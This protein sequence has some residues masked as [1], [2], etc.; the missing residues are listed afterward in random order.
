MHFL[1]NKFVK[2][3]ILVI[4]LQVLPLIIFGCGG[5]GGGGS[6]GG[7]VLPV[8]PTNTPSFITQ[9]LTPGQP[10]NVNIGDNCILKFSG[11]SVTQQCTI[12]CQLVQSK[13]LPNLPAGLQTL[14][15]IYVIT[16]DKPSAYVANSANLEIT[17]NVSTQNV[18]IYTDYNIPSGTVWTNLNTTINGQKLS[19][20]CPGFSNTGTSYVAVGP[21]NLPTETPSPT[22][23]ALTP[24][25]APGAPTPTPVLGTPTSTPIVGTPTAIPPT[26]TPVTYTVTYNVNGG[27]GGNA[28]VDSNHYVQGSTVT[29]LDFTGK[30]VKPS[31]RWAGWNTQADGLGTDRAVGST[32]TASSNVTLYAKWT[33]TP[34]ALRVTGPAGGLIFYDKGSY[35]GSPAWRYLEAAP[36]DYPENPGFPQHSL[37]PWDDSNPNVNI[38]GGTA[39]GIGTG[40]Q[41]TINIVVSKGSDSYAALVCY[42]LVISGYDDWFLP[43]KDELDKIYKELRLFGVGGFA[44]SYYWSSSAYSLQYAWEQN[45]IN[46][47]QGYTSK[48]SSLSVRAV[49]AF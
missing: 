15:D 40:Q 23:G 24:T 7:G 6:T 14:S 11:N 27:N 26:P 19:T 37:P 18:C 17:I 28:P 21:S 36:S 41:N 43:S 42:E 2:L 12:T 31:Y 22:P 13:A 34:Y 5:G 30:L 9:Q 49:R 4:L 29:V 20:L 48:A 33:D 45:F 38:I 3:I 10:S 25:L 35:S 1:R 44:D 16:L 46:G 47:S 8:A 39:T 32:F